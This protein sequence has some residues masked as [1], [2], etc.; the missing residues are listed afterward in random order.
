LKRWQLCK[1][2]IEGVDISTSEKA[3]PH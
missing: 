1:K 2:I 3:W